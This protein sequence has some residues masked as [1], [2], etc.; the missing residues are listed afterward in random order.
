MARVHYPAHVMRQTQ[1]SRRQVI[2]SALLCGGAMGLPDKA[3]ARTVASL[4]DEKA[5]PLAQRIRLIEKQRILPRAD[6][7]SREPVQ[8]ITEYPAERS[9]DDRHAYYSEGDYWWPNPANPGGPYIRRDGQSN[10]NRFEAHRLAL[11]R[12]S[13]IVPWLA[14][15]HRLTGKRRYLVAMQRHLDGWFVNPETRMVPHLEHAQ[16]IIG[17]NKGR[18]TG[19]IDTLHLVE[20]ARACLYADRLG[21]LK[22]AR[23]IKDWFAAYLEWMLTSPNGRDEG[24]EINNHGTTYM[25][26]VAAFAEF[27]SHEEHIL[28]TGRQM[29]EILIPA[30]LEPNG[31]QPLELARTKPYGYALF[32]LEAMACLAHLLRPYG[33]NL[34]TFGTADGRSLTKA[35]RWMEP[36]IRDKS[37]WPMAKDV[38]YFANWPMRQMS[39]L[40]AAD[41]LDDDGLFALWSSLPSDSEVPEIIRN[42]PIRQPLLWV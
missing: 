23:A 22:N 13:R 21:K 32:N 35:M 7:F 3:F 27:L 33:D 37:K 5:A 36:Y 40:Y 1:P 39:L 41:A 10:P 18:G 34:W 42:T 14:S 31:R 15:A 4:E 20:V 17:V 8:T 12:L 26:Q 25:L 11:I 28:W 24:D 30:Q 19:I 9:P 6:R 29:R 16:A 2:A 38:E